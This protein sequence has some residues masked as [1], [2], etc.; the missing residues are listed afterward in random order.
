MQLRLAFPGPKQRGGARAGAGRKRLPAG[1]RY[2]PHRAR[3]V[4]RSA[5]P[6][7]VTMRAGLR[8][9][10]HPFVAQTVRA[11]L[12]AANRSDFRI[13]HWSIQPNH[14]HLIVEAQSSESLSSA[15]RGLAVR[16][17][18]RVNRL[19]FRRGSFWVDRWYGVELT[20]PRQVRNALVYVLQNHA[21]HSASHR[22]ARDPLS[23]AASFDGFAGALPQARGSPAPDSGARTWL[24]RVGWTRHGLIRESEV[25]AR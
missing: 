16:V 23:S 24:L 15:M 7:H 14:L 10:R 20:S 8:S 9:L 11:A 4:H 6:V 17:A 22:A 3:S 21:K 18:R 13:V 2:T 1:L 5:H 25:P 19:L 12:Q